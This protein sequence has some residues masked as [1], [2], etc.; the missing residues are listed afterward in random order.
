MQLPRPSL[1]EATVLIAF[2]LVLA[3]VGLN[4]VAG[5]AFPHVDV[6]VSV[7]A[8]GRLP[9]GGIGSLLVTLSTSAAP[10]EPR[11]FIVEGPAVY[12]W[13][14]DGPHALDASGTITYRISAP[15]SNCTIPSGT[16]FLV[17]VYDV[18]SRSYSFS[19]ALRA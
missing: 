5:G 15:C 9:S 11:F 7:P 6:T 1:P 3:A 19:P 2:G 17:R 4:A 18:I 12:A 10:L 13:N 16:I 8:G 14:A